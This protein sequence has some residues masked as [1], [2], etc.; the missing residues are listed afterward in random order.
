MAGSPSDKP[1]FF[2]D[3]GNKM[4]KPKKHSVELRPDEYETLLRNPMIASMCDDLLKSPCRRGDYLVFNLTEGQLKELT[5]WVAAEANHAKT[6]EEEE[7]LGDVCDGL[8]S[9]LSGISR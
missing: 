2:D 3:N 6:I 1:K 7:A 4:K 8:E 9:A 5:G